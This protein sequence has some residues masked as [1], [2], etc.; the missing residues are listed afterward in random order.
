MCLGGADTR[1]ARGRVLM[2]G[3]LVV[4]RGAARPSMGTVRRHWSGAST[5]RASTSVGTCPATGWALERVREDRLRR[6]NLALA[7]R[8]RPTTRLRE[9]DENRFAVP[10]APPGAC[11]AVGG[12]SPG[13]GAPRLSAATPGDTDLKMFDLAVDTGSP[14]DSPARGRCCRS[15]GNR[16][17]TQFWSSHRRFRIRNKIAIT[18]SAIQDISGYRTGSGRTKHER[19]GRGKK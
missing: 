12:H 16:A 9:R 13:P 7:H 18:P 1:T 2:G 8:A 14:A 6:L 15:A 5:L 4:S 10:C 3:R 17:A 11:R 19:T